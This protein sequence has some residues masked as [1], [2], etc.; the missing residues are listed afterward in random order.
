MNWKVWI[1]FVVIVG[2][3]T[4]LGVVS[5][6]PNQGG[7]VEPSWEPVTDVHVDL[8]QPYE[9]EVTVT[10][11]AEK[12]SDE[13]F[14]VVVAA[15]RVVQ[16]LLPQYYVPY[17]DP[18]DVRV[19][20]RRGQVSLRFPLFARERLEFLFP[21]ATLVGSWRP[22]WESLHFTVVLPAGYEVTGTEQVGLEEDLEV[23]QGPRWAVTGEES[24]AG[25]SDF[26]ITY[27]RMDGAGGKERQ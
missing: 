14:M 2:V 23:E 16:T 7:I 21:E 10:Y 24:T 6:L 15:Q 12:A 5:Y 8:D 27:A 3:T 17:Q 26:L 9:G 13:D 19:R 20:R 25:W 11:P 18:D 22:M 1:S 4:A